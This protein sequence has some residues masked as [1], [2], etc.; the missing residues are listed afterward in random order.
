[1][2][3]LGLRSIPDPKISL[4]TRLERLIQEEWGTLL[5]KSGT[6]VWAQETAF[7]TF[8][9]SHWNRTVQH[10]SV[11]S[12][13]HNETGSFSRL[14]HPDDEFPSPS[15]TSSELFTEVWGAYSYDALSWRNRT[16]GKAVLCDHPGRLSSWQ[17]QG[18]VSKSSFAKGMN[19]E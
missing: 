5:D 14:S 7:Q 6:A 16:W 4:N 1:M 19:S 11:L 8:Q 12:D 17:T 10:L 18:E 15:Q 2:C 3:L 13:I 9:S